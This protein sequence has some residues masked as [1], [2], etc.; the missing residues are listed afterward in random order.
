MKKLSPSN[1]EVTLDVI[2]STAT[3]AA[4]FLKANPK[5]DTILLIDIPANYKVR[6][7]VP[8]DIGKPAVDYVHE[9]EVILGPGQVLVFKKEEQVLLAGSSSLKRVI[10]TEVR[11]HMKP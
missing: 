2:T 7:L 1:K 8:G 9:N 10:Y 6:A 11:C 4:G 5:A 3:T